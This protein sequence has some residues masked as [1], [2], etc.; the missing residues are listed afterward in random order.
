MNRADQ[1]PEPSI[2]ELLASIRLI[3]SDADKQGPS[4][5]EPRTQAGD[6]PGELPA[7]EV[8]DLTDEL[9]FPEEPAR[10]QLA[11]SQ[12]GTRGQ[13]GLDGYPG[14][15]AYPP[16]RRGGASPARTMHRRRC[17]QPKSAR[18]P[19]KYSVRSRETPHTRRSPGPFGPAASCLQERHTLRRRRGPGRTHL[20][21]PQPEAGLGIFRCRYPKKVR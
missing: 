8:F 16:P 6:L 20:Q 5:K 7:G 10:P 11:S 1:A 12:A 3:I 4:Q 21:G 9:L 13:Q 18:T 2:E 17:G 19:R 15:Q 14:Q